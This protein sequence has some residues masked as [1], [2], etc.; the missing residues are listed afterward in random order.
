MERASNFGAGGLEVAERDSRRGRAGATGGAGVL[1][2]SCVGPGV[3]GRRGPGV[4]DL[5]DGGA[6]VRDRTEAGEGEGVVGRADKEED[7]V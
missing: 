6:G 4:Y 5:I 1:D 7:L 2:R 3:G